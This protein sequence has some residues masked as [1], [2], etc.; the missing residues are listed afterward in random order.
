MYSADGT[1]WSPYTLYK[2]QLVNV[3]RVGD[4]NE[5]MLNGVARIVGVDVFATDKVIVQ[6]TDALLMPA[7]VEVS[8][9]YSSQYSC[10]KY[11]PLYVVISLIG[12]QEGAMLRT[13]RCQKHVTHSR[14]SIK[15]HFITLAKLVLC[16]KTKLAV[17]SYS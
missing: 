16:S 14:E 12:N 5:I 4:T 10:A 13:R 17:N 8:L 15:V 3:T 6:G 11:F 7:G 9:Q 2:F 1:S